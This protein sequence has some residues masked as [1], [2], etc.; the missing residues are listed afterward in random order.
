MK[1]IVVLG[2]LG[3]FGRTVIEQLKILGISTMIAARRAAADIQVDA[4]EP[5]SIRTSFSAGDLVIDAAG[6]FQK[7]SMA[8]LEAAIEIGFDLVDLN[9]NLRYAEQVLALEGSIAR[10]GICVLSSASS[11]SAVAAAIVRQSKVKTPVRV[12]GFLAPAS[13]HTAN[14]GSALSL[15]QSVGRPVRALRDG[16]LQTIRGWSETRRFAMPDPVGLVCG[17]L[18]ETADAVYLP[19]IWPSLRE[20]DM[21]VDP[22]TPGV[23]TLL[24]LA[25]RLPRFRRLLERQVRL[26]TWISTTIGSTAG[27]IGY[28]IEDASGD[29]ARFAIFSGKNSFVTAVAPAVLATRAIVDGRLQSTGL[30]LPDRHV[31]PAE[32][33]AYLRSS[34][35][36][37]AQMQ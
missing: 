20:V 9:D 22:N 17:R 26:G 36:E 14:R 25:A 4:N 28:E 27:G 5:V 8:L 7:R 16:R 35:V 24:W 1:R 3:F 30:V 32:L 6:P 19:R 18:F 33:V 29:V 34:D 12:T 31:D 23:N 21:V 11:V 37:V 13:R 10:A 15:I 2:G